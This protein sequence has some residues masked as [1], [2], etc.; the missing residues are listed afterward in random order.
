MENN[1]LYS[2]CQHGFRR[3]KSCTSQLLEV[4]EDFTSF[5]EGRENFDV[6]YL[7]FKKAFDSVPHER[8]MLKLEGYGITGNISNW[9]RSFLA[10][11]TQRVKIGDQFSETSKVTSGIPQGSILGPILFTIF[12]NDLPESINSICKIFADDT[13]IYNTSNKHDMIQTDLNALISWSNKW[14][15]Y[16]NSQKCKCLHH[17]K[18]NPKHEYYLENEN[19]R[20]VLPKGEEELDLG[21]YFTVNLKFDKQVNEAVRKANMVLGLIKRNFCYIDRD[22]FNKLYKSLVR[23]HLEYAQEVWQPYLKKHSILMEKVQRRATKLVPE[24]KKLK[25]EQR[26]AILNLPSLKYR[27]LRGDMILTFNLFNNGDEDTN[28]KLL[29]KHA[30]RENNHT[31]GHNRKLSK[32]SYSLNIREYSFSQRIVNTWNAL[33]PYIIN[34]KDTDTFKRLF[35]THM[36]CHMLVYDE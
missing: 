2:K 21:V 24:L 16:F 25:Y 23:P 15:L 17:G 13:K 35:D 9:I 10:G 3:K 19:G 33:P 22:V 5:M 32:E 31:R 28:C 8:L 1:K 4:M 34:A 27:R 14:Q 36:S 6:I 26:L 18:S 11:R 12:I 7:D 30:C 29:K 20:E